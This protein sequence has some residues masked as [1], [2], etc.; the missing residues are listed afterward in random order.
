MPFF[1]EARRFTTVASKPEYPS[2]EEQQFA[3]EQGR[4]TGLGALQ[5]GLDRQEQV[6]T[7]VISRQVPLRSGKRKP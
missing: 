5:G 7:K 4:S 6:H 3:V 1:P 2:S